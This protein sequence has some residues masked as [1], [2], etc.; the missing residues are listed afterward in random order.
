MET[1]RF[2]QR[3][4]PAFAFDLI[5]LSNGLVLLVVLLVPLERLYPVRPQ[6]IFRRGWLSDGVYYYLSSLLPNRL[7]ALPLSVLAMGILGMGPWTLHPWVSAWPLWA[8]FAGALVVGEVGF[9]WGHR[10]MH[11]HEWL[12]RFHAVH[13][14]A[15]RLDWLVNTRAHPVDLVFTR[16]C[17][18]VP[19]YVLG[20]ARP[21][22]DTLDWVPLLVALVGAMWGY[23]IHANVRW[24]FGWLEHVISTPGFHHWHH[25][26]EGPRHRHKNYAPLLPWVDRLFG[27]F[28]LDRA[29]WPEIYGIDEPFEHGLVGQLVRPFLPSAPAPLPPAPP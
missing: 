8:R 15:A 21:S 2:L 7:L 17:G 22:A 10:L 4:L 6:P 20:F 13:H 9:Y 24:R 11:Q 27:T 14:S 28:H 19:I 25:Q 23:F 1:L 3:H 18:Y 12:W 5:K 26:N 29:S 16:L